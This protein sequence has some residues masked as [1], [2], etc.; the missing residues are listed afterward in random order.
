M[1]NIAFFI[2]QLKPHIIRK[3][4]TYP[5]ISTTAD[6]S[7]F[8]Q[9]TMEPGD[10]QLYIGSSCDAPALFD[11]LPPDA[12]ATFFLSGDSSALPAWFSR[13]FNIISTDLSLIELYSRV[14]RIL[15]SYQTWNRTLTDALRQDNSLR[16]IVELAGQLLQGHILLFNPGMHLLEYTRADFFADPIAEEAKK[17]GFLSYKTM[18]ELTAYVKASPSYAH[19]VRHICP[20]DSDHQL[21]LHTIT[22]QG[23]EIANLMFIIDDSDCHLDMADMISQMGGF[24]R[25][26][27]IQD[28]N[29]L[30]VSGSHLA[31]LLNDFASDL[32]LSPVE[33]R[34][35]IRLL[36]YPVRKYIRCI[37]VTFREEPQPASCNLLLNRLAQLLPGTN[38]TIWNAS[39]I[40]LHSADKQEFKNISAI[41]MDVWNALLE[42]F[43]AQ[44][45]ISNST[46]AYDSFRS[47]YY[48]TLRLSRV[49]SRMQITNPFKNMVFYADYALYLVI[50]M[51]AEQFQTKLSNNDIILLAAPAV[52]TLTR[53]DQNHNAN[54]RDVLYHYLHNGRSVSRTA[55]IMY[56]HRNT[57]L[58]KLKKIQE[59]CPMDLEDGICTEILLFSCQLAKYY[60]EY[61]NLKLRI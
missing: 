34:D 48:L 33:I 56:M 25:P 18:Q 42:E 15:R 32:A 43:H 28:T 39:I 55:E 58:N 44:A 29:T 36:P 60:E 7:L 30:S 17:D 35:R 50:D 13:Q 10:N 26:L 37:I 52:I 11:K 53:Y 31:S 61:M 1:A 16:H 51:A 46:S 14:S 4:I 41:R 20:E 24:L 54:L 19:E 47:V 38:M 2:K 45:T 49:L 3:N 5:E 57:V 40:I 8:D 9:H 6:I 27:L 23:T 12:R 59:L 21:Y 22:Y